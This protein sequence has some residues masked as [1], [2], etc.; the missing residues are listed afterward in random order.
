ME[1]YKQYKLHSNCSQQKLLWKQKESLHGFG[2]QQSVSIRVDTWFHHNLCKCCW[3]KQW[4]LTCSSE[5]WVVT[6]CLL[7]YSSVL[8]ATCKAHN[9]CSFIFSTS[10]LNLSCPI[11]YLKVFKRVELDETQ[12][13][14]GF[15]QEGGREV[16]LTQWIFTFRTCM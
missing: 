14:E 2:T 1:M 3:P 12:L 4:L 6:I 7:L 9:Y 8:C 16:L 10:Q 5:E 15:H 11:V 13:K